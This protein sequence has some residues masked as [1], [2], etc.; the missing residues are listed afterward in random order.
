MIKQKTS[1]NAL[2]IEQL[3]KR[4]DNLTTVLRNSKNAGTLSKAIIDRIDH[5]AT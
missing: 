1:Q 3:A 4:I 2:D 5:L